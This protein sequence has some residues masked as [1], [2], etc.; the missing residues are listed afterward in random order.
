MKPMFTI[1]ACPS[2]PLMNCSALTNDACGRMP[3]R[4]MELIGSWCARREKGFDATAWGL[5]GRLVRRPG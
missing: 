1:I 5:G 2:V 4:Q 3:P